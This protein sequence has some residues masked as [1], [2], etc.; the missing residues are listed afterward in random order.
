MPPLPRD[1]SRLVDLVPVYRMGA[2]TQPGRSDGGV[3]LKSGAPRSRTA[4]THGSPCSRL[5][6]EEGSS[7]YGAHIFPN[8][9]LDFGGTFATLQRII[10]RAADRS[11][12]IIEYLFAP[13]TIAD[14][15]LTPTDVVEF[16]ELV[17]AQDHAI[18]ERVSSAWRRTR[19]SAECTH[20]RIRARCTSTRCTRSCS[21][22]SLERAL[23]TTQ[24]PDAFRRTPAVRLIKP[25]GWDSG[26][27]RSLTPTAGFPDRQ[28][29]RPRVS[30]ANVTKSAHLQ[31]FLSGAAQ[32]SNLPTVGLQRPAGFEDRAGL[33]QRSGLSGVCAPDRAPCG[34]SMSGFR[35]GGAGGDGGASVGALGWA[36]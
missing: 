6:T 34:R 18:C 32:E 1:P 15:T 20:R 17:V 11:T 2:V 21:A 25:R 10:P 13:E 27:R 22:R 12:R 36:V 4:E 35:T 3:G 33:A 14:P 9:T 19:S 23:P 5:T 24:Q 30:H 16:N 29:G 8:V 31:G 26:P 28:G 7:Y